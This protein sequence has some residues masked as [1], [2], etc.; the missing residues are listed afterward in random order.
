MFTPK[1]CSNLI[2]MIV[3]LCLVLVLL[4]YGSIRERNWII[5]FSVINLGFVWRVSSKAK[6]VIKFTDVGKELIY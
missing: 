1:L 2:K 6:L 5:H 3:V 4:D